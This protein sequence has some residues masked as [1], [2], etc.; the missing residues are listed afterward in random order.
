MLHLVQSEQG[1]VSPDGIAFCADSAGPDQ[2]AG[3]GGRRPSTRCTSASR[4]AST[5]SASAP[6]RCAAC[7]AATRSTTR[8]REQLG[9]GNNETTADGTITLEHA[10]CLA[11]CDYAPVMTVN[12]E[13]FDNQTAAVAARRWSASCATASGRCRPAARRCA[14]SRRSPARSPG[15]FDDERASGPRPPAPAP[16]R[17]RRQAGDRPRRSPRRPTR[18]PTTDA[19]Q[20]H[21]GDEKA[22][23]PVAERGI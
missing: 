21:A 4:P 16:D 1:Y 11:A 5:W 7:S 6:T 8:S 10:E 14:P 23:R 18:P 9:V 13:F 19:G 22:A 12:Y 2:G 3:R 17:G 15:F 20:R